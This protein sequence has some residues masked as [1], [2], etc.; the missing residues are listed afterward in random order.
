MRILVILFIIPVFFAFQSK[1]NDATSIVEINNY[2]SWDSSFVIHLYYGGGMRYMSKNIYFRHD[3]CIVINMDQ[4]IDL[5]SGFVM[6]KDHKTTV[7]SLLKKHRFFNLKQSENRGFA[8]DKAT[9]S[10][11]V[12]GKEK[13]CVSSGSSTEVKENDRTDF[14]DLFHALETFAYENYSSD[15]KKKK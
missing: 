10:I 14:N 15:K 1:K 4:G 6:N 9:T 12:E 3:S 13:Y 7:L 5:Y 11:C 2:D 8:H